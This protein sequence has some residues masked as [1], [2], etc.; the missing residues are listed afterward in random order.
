VGIALGALAFVHVDPRVV[1]VMIGAVTLVFVAKWLAGGDVSRTP[2]PPS[3]LRAAF[4]GG[5][6]GFPTFIAHSGGPPL[7]I[8]LLPLRLEKTIYAGTTVGFFAIGNLLKLGPYL[9]LASFKLQL[10]WPFLA[11]SPVVPL[12]VWAGRR[13]HRHLSESV[14]YRVC[15]GLLSLA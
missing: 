5:V 9:W 11:I 8:Y 1:V 7:A 4:W 15:Y 6:S 3:R 12:G 10:V 14:V 13:L 2:L